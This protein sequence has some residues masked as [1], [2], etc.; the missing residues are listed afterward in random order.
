MATSSR[1]LAVF[2][3]SALLP[4]SAQ[5][6]VSSD[7]RPGVPNNPTPGSIPEGALLV[8]GATSSASDSETA[9]PESGSVSNNTYTNRYFGLSFPL[10]ADWI[11]KSP[12]PPPSDSGR[13]GL[14]LLTPAPALKGLAGGSIL[15]TAQDMFFTPDPLTHASD[16]VDFTKSH[17]QGDYKIEQEPSDAHIA[18]QRFISFGYG[19]PSTGLHWRIL[20]T[21][22][23]CH[24]LEFVFMNR[25]P[26][27]LDRLVREANAIDLDSA[28]ST[29]S[30]AAQDDVP[31]CIK[32]YASAGNVIERVDPLF[33][34]HRYNPVPVRIIVGKDGRIRHIHFLNAFPDQSKAVTEALNHWKFKPYIRDGKPVEVE[35]G[36]MFGSR[37]PRLAALSNPTSVAAPAR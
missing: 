35:T 6:I 16:L 20:A 32:A 14:T 11:Q 1:L 22:I 24:T 23:R 13:Y 36:I 21:E 26:Q 34:E 33:T 19:S 2:I 5:S 12:G 31:V 7:S 27:T 3:A 18:G 25:D 10:P 30:G 8:K 4:L 15:I 28:V 37:A 29:L 17:L 9:L